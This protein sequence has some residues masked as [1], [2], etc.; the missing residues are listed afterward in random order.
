MEVSQERIEENR[1]LVEEL[2]FIR[3]NRWVDGK[4]V[5]DDKFE[6]T[7]IDNLPPGW[8]NIAIDMF[9]EIK[10]Y[11]LEHGGQ[12]ALDTFRIEQLKEKFGSIR[13]YYWPDEDGISEI[14]Q[15]H[16]WRS[17]ITCCECGKPATRMSTGWICPYCDDCGS[18]EGTFVPIENPT[19]ESMGE[20]MDKALEW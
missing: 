6:Y 14:I 9:R 13:C 16:E 2:P 19:K 10:K 8:R 7:E 18:K 3:L 15:K 5:P 17:E 11:L 20:T 12:E 1:K 4:T